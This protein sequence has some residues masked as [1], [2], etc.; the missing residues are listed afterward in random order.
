M[1]AETPAP[2]GTGASLSER[3]LAGDVRAMARAISLVEDEASA[4]AELIRRIYEGTSQIQ[5]VVI[6][7]E[8]QKGA[9][10]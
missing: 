4:G 5:Q 8:M 10:K 3:V 6:A 9:G 7:R 2:L 1:P